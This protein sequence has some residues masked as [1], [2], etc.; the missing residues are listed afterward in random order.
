[1]YEYLAA[2][3]IFDVTAVSALGLGYLYH[4]VRLANT[5]ALTELAHYRLAY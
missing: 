4:R 5:Q 3:F 1:M 2:L